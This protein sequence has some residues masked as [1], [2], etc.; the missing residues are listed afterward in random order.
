MSALDQLVNLKGVF[1]KDSARRAESVLKSVERVRI[2][3]ADRLIQ[4]HETLLF[5]RAYPQSPNVV[6]LTDKL[7]ATF[8]DRVR[9][10]E[11]A[12]FEA[13][14]VSGITGTAISTNFSYPFARSLAD[15]HGRA[16]QID[17]ENYA[18][19]DRLGSV[20]ARIAPMAAED[21]NVESHVD[22]QKWFQKLKG[23]LQWLLDRVEPSTYDLLE[24]PLLWSI[25]NSSA[26]RSICRLNRKAI[27]Y[28]DGPLI[29]R[30][31]VSL[32]AEL[33]A[34]S[35]PTRRV[36][37]SEARAV[38]EMIVDTSAVRYR[39]LWGFLYPD[40]ERVLHADLGRGV[41]L[42]WFGVV[43][44]HRLPLRA[45]HSGM[46]FKNGVPM[47]YVETLSFFE[48][49]EVG[50]NLYY[51]FRDGESAWLYAR[52]LKFCRQ[53]LG[54][55]CFSIDPYQIGHENEEAVDSG[56]FWFYRK[57]GFR[58]AAG[59]VADLLRREE[60]KMAK[61]PS[62]RSTPTT[63][64]RLAAERIFYGDPNGWEKFSIRAL[65]QKLGRGELPMDAAMRR[66]KKGPDE[67]RYLRLLQRS[68]K[69]RQQVLRL[70]RA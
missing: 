67:A 52:L 2:R 17:W 43:P 62:H 61:S 12:P 48:L 6:R 20:L 65:A 29:H 23:T 13:A 37:I 63:L 56:A 3:D 22:W 21:W 49:A 45:Y 35:I 41:D 44:E 31:E 5:L 24:I 34:P 69:L 39:E 57:L 18:H 60:E 33:A 53:Q 30:R 32:D 40:L 4:L 55:T 9:G 38:M 11:Q 36:P 50:F 46:F 26:A 47:G 19:P 16:I 27:F 14:E 66:A 54:V 10:L 51:T 68:P 15:R 8:G 7:L 28:H 70:G 58:P 1:G 42:Y 25:S 59:P 64:R